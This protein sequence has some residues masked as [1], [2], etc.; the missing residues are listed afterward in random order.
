MNWEITHVHVYAQHSYHTLVVSIMYSVQHMYNCVCVC[1]GD[2]YNKRS[3]ESRGE[4]TAGHSPASP[5]LASYIHLR[6]QEEGRVINASLSDF[7]AEIGE[8]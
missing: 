3:V 6:G 5:V 2:M 1:V 4:S 8:R 7:S